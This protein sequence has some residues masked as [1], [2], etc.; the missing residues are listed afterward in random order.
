MRSKGVARFESSIP[1]Q[2]PLFTYTLHRPMPVRRY[3]VALTAVSATWRL[4][5]VDAAFGAHKVL[6]AVEVQVVRL[7]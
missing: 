1:T 7:R 5:S 6:M 2:Q 4:F 3:P